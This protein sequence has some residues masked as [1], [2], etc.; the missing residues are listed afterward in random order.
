VRNNKD[1]FGVLLSYAF[2]QD[3]RCHHSAQNKTASH[4]DKTR[5]TSC[6]ASVSVIIK[7]VNKNTCKND[8][9]LRRVWVFYII[10]I[11]YQYIYILYLW[12]RNDS[13]IRISSP[14]AGKI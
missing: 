5:S 3:L 10:D 12:I 6:T 9:F 1:V 13:H 4:P 7:H 2:R 8:S 14:H 11:L